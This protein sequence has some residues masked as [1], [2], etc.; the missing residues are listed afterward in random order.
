M[1]G[2]S[3]ITKISFINKILKKAIMTRSRLL[4]RYRKETTEGTR[5]ACKRQRKFC[6]KLLRKIKKEF[7]NNLK[8]KFITENKLFWKIAKPSY[9][10]KTLKDE[11]IT[12]V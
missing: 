2:M 9:T 7:Y 12:L 3:D 10:D 5:S 8:V 6:V 1:N 11:R 4:N